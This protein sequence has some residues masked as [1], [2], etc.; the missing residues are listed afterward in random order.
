MLE[1]VTFVRWFGPVEQFPD[2]GRFNEPGGGGSPVTG[3]NARRASP[4]RADAVTLGSPSRRPSSSASKYRAWAAAVSPS[5]SWHR[6]EPASATP[7]TTGVPRSMNPS[8]AI[9]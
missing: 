4:S 6:P 1:V 9:A 8:T 7:S 3:G 2:A 5:A